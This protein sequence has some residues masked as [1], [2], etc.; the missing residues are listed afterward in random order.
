[1]SL[2]NKTLDKTKLNYLFWEIQNN[3]IKRNKTCKFMS[4]MTTK[5]IQTYYLSLIQNT[6]PLF[7]LIYVC[8]WIINKHN[9]KF[10]ALCYYFNIE[11][12]EEKLAFSVLQQ[13]WY[14]KEHGNLYNQISFDNIIYF[15]NFYSNEL[16]IVTRNASSTRRKLRGIVVVM[17]V[18]L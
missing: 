9:K 10:H 5:K 8:H 3:E 2:S 6:P 13:C 15:F 11:I 17:F 1:M 4:S 16:R 7:L 12:I 18:S 14:K